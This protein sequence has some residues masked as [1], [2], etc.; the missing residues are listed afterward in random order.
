MRGLP[1]A[2]SLLYKQLLCLD[3]A[4]RPTREQ[5]SFAKQA[6]YQVLVVNRQ[7]R[8]HHRPS[9][10]HP[11]TLACH[12]SSSIFRQANKMMRVAV[13]MSLL[14]VSFLCVATTASPVWKP[15]GRFGKRLDSSSLLL[16]S[17]KTPVSGE[18]EFPVETLASSERPSFLRVM[19]RPCTVSGVAGYPPCG[20]NAAV[21]EESTGS[22]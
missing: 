8:C 3:S 18:I 13:A 10:H 1:M 4:T 11:T 14:V 6:T 5:T 9:Y 20:W 7:L 22:I 12:L 17:L 16:D 21:A 15:Q 2:W 19:V